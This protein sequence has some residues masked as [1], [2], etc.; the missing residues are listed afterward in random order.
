MKWSNAGA[1]RRAA[2]A[3]LA[4]TL[5]AVVAGPHSIRATDDREDWKNRGQ[6]REDLDHRDEGPPIQHV[7]VIFQENVSFDHYFATYPHA[8]NTDGSPFVAKA[9]TPLVNGLFLGGLLDHNPNSVQPFRLSHAEV[10]TC[11][12]DHNYKD[13][14]AA[15]NAG[16]M[17]RFPETVG[18]GGSPCD[19][20]KGTGLVMGYF[21]GNTVTAF[22]NYAQN[23]AMS[24]NSY[25]T[26]FGPSTPGA[27]NV[28]AGQTHGATLAPD[29]YAK[30]GSASGNVTA[31]DATGVGSVIGDPRPAPAFDNCTLPSNAP[32]GSP[33]TYITMTGRNVGD[34]LNERHVTWGWF[35]GGFR[36][37]ANGNSTLTNVPG[38]TTQA[39]GATIP[40][41]PATG[42][43]GSAHTSGFGAGASFDYI[44]HHEPFQYFAQ[45]SN[46][47]HLPPSSTAM[48]GHSDQANHQYDLLDFWAAFDAGHLPSVSYLKAAAYQ[49]GHAG[50]SSPLD[51][52]TFLVETINRLM[53]SREWEHTAVIV[54]YDDSDG[55]YDHQMGPIVHQS[56]ALDPV[57]GLPDDGL[58]GTGATANCGT[59]SA[60]KFNGRCGYGPRQPLL[61]ISPWARQNFVDHNVTDQSSVVRFIEDNWG[62]GRIDNQSSDAIAGSLRGM[63]DFN[64]D[65]ARASELILNS[66]TGNP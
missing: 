50:Y 37:A 53:Q 8:T 19:Q 14:Q 48:I 33:R 29:F 23:F 52:Q 12:Q 22:W 25:S 58:F 16:G 49:D 6:D 66:V 15:F 35:Q 63:F 7:V 40:M 32:P 44:P 10:A 59:P 64:E 51:E 46:P 42:I 4:A 36:P 56:N 11:D 3:L 13:E 54:L 43:C 41:F 38:A 18:V 57:S 39:A 60:G 45:T 2:K 34:L 26:T 61:V 31:I 21:D 24:D 27:L 20:G 17:N 5:V 47:R 9:G 62:L 28:I 1:I 30:T 65:H 55:W